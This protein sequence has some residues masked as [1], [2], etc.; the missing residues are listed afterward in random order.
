MIELVHKL[1]KREGVGELFAD[2]V[3]KAAEKIGPKSEPFAMDIAGEELPMHDAKL[4]PE[5]F[6]TY[7]LDPTPA[8][9]TL[10]N[11]RPTDPWGVPAPPHDAKQASGR[12]PHHKGASEYMHV[13]NS[14]G[15]CMFTAFGGPNHRIPEWVNAVTGW[16][17]D[18]PE[19]LK[20]GERIGNM[21]M[22]FHVLHGDNPVQRRI[23]GRL[24]G[25]PP[26]EAG[27]H[28][29]FT[30]DTETL[31]R[32]FLEACDWDRQTCRP[33]RAKLEELGLKDVADVLYA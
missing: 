17:T 30:L 31:E 7:K 33:S 22:A 11:G 10:Y 27:P 26:L 13:V 12:A 6:A 1:V 19:M 20:T 24:V 2:G 4:Q 14:I 5:Y 8:R 28:T 32:E 23:P 18:L 21:R 16:D 3:R 29:G 9:H 25:K 15:F